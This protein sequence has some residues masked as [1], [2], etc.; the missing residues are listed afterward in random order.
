MTSPSF[1]SIRPWPSVSTTSTF[2]YG[3]LPEKR[4]CLILKR[5][6]KK[7]QNRSSI[8]CSPPFGF[9]LSFIVPSLIGAGPVADYPAS[10]RRLR[11]GGGPVGATR[12]RHVRAGSASVDGPL[13]RRWAGGGC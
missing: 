7:F 12:A 8:H 6:A 4:I 11:S 3:L 5:V 1:K 10:A 2:W 9:G 13:F